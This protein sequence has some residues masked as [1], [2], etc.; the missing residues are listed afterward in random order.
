MPTK[1]GEERAV[2]T[3]LGSDKVGIVAKV[4]NTLAEHNANIIDISQTLLDDLFTMIMLVEVSDLSTDFE[5]FN[6]A[7]T[8][9]SDEL[10]VKV[11]L[12][13]EEVFRYM[14]RI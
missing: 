2:V 7:L 13:H 12:Q 10:E 6:Q 4:A 11:K 3:V 5:S 9:L 14:H 1:Q 8:E